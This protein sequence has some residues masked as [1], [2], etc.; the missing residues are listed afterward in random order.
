MSGVVIVAWSAGRSSGAFRSIDR[1][2]VS[3]RGPVW[4]L[5]P[6]CS[7]SIW[8]I[9]LPATAPAARAGEGEATATAGDGEGPTEAGA[10]G[11]G[12]ATAEGE[13]V[14]GPRH[15]SGALGGF[16]V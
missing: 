15:A 10:H 12:L 13:T 3:C 9:G 6:V 5:R 7:G 8:Y 16:V 1:T 11:D 14:D 4:G 2:S